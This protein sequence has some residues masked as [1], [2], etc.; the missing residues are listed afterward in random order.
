MERNPTKRKHGQAQL[1]GLTEEPE[2]AQELGLA[3]DTLRKYRKRGKGGGYL[4]I[5]RA[6]YYTP[7]HKQAWLKAFEQKPVRSRHA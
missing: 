2:F 6:I 5:G 1:P 3:P 4:Q 7:D